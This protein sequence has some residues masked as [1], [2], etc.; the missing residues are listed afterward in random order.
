MNILL[1]AFAL[2]IAVIIFSIALQR[3]FNSPIL[4]GAIIFAIFLVV[5]FVVNDLMFLV[6]TIIYT[7]LA[8]LTAFIVIFIEN[9]I[10]NLDDD[11]DDDDDD[12]H[13]HCG[14]NNREIEDIE[15][16]EAN[17]NRPRYVCNR[18]LRRL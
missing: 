18:Y 14:C 2:P 12:Y 5:T 6:Y 3:I 10:D 4:V 8:I 13:H 17:I 7:F 9:Y 1:L 11:D 15:A 16:N